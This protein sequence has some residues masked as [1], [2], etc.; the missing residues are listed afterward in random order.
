MYELWRLRLFSFGG[1]GLALAALALMVFGAIECPPPLTFLCLKT[2]DIE[3]NIQRCRSYFWVHDLQTKYL[4]RSKPVACYWYSDKYVKELRFSLLPLFA[5]SRFRAPEIFGKDDATRSSRVLRVLPTTCWLLI[6]SVTCVA[7]VSSGLYRYMR[8]YSWARNS[9]R[10]TP[11]PYFL[12]FLNTKL[13]C[14]WTC[15]QKA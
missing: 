10:T 13:W 11:S 5:A 12:G 8:K 7:F 1:Y 9:L 2:G 3:L 15:A 4:I 14:H 6:V